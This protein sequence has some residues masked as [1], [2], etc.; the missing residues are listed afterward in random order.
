M[1]SDTRVSANALA[2]YYIPGSNVPSLQRWQV[3][4][5]DP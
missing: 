3:A 5:Q 2:L 4:C 1:E